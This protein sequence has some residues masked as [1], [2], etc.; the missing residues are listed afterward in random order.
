MKK[1]KKQLYLNLI[2]YTSG[3][4]YSKVMGCGTSQAMDC[5][6]HIVY[7]GRNA[8]IINMMEKRMKVMNPEQASTVGEIEAKMTAWKADMRYLR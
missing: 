2:Q 7:K 8:T 1:I 3:D 4:A 6:R 5:Y